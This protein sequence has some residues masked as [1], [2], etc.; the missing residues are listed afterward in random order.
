MDQ[1]KEPDAGPHVRFC[2]RRDGAIHCAYSTVP[3]GRRPKRRNLPE[4][5]RFAGSNPRVLRRNLIGE[6]QRRTRAPANRAAT[7]D[8]WEACA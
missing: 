7:D 8:L 2:E 6:H 3:C 4:P 1:P 5:S